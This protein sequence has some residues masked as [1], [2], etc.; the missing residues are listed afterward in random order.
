MTA[1]PRRTLGHHCDV[2]RLL[3]FGSASA[4]WALSF[5][6]SRLVFGDSPLAASLVGLVPFGLVFIIT[7]PRE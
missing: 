6:V 5:A 4:A 3:S 1:D 2:L 7:Y